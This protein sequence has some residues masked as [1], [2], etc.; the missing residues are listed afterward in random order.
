MMTKKVFLRLA[1]TLVCGLS[2]ARSGWG[3]E[4]RATLGGRVADPQGATVPNAQ[5]EVISDDTGVKQ[6][7]TTNSDGNW[8]VR[9]LIPGHYRFTVTSP[10]FKVAV[11]TGI[12]L[13][14]ADMKSID[15]ELTV[16]SASDHVTVTAEA[17][18]IDTTAA[19]SGTVIDEK[20]MLEVPTNSR[21]AS[22]FAVLSPGVLQQDQN[23]NVYQLWSY[24]A[25]SQFTINGGTNNS[26]S[27]AFEL[28]GMP[29]EM[30]GGKVAFVA[31]PD[32][33]QEFRVLMN[34][35]DAS[36]GRQAGG[37]VQMSLRSGTARYHG[38]LFELNQNNHLNANTF[39]ANLS[40][41]PVPQVHYNE[42][43][44]T[45]GGPVWIPKVYHGKQ[46]TFFFVSNDNFRK[47][48][49]GTGVLG[50][51]TA[52]ERQGDFS[53]SFTTQQ[54]NGQTVRYPIQVYDPLTADSSGARALF[55]GNV[56]P[57]S[58]L[59]SIA[60]NILK[61]VPLPNRPSDPTGNAVNNFASSQPQPGPL[62]LIAV[63]VDQS[64]SDM[65]KTF[66]N[67]RWSSA[68]LGGSTAF[69]KKEFVT[70]EGRTPKG[71]G[72]DHV[73]TV[74]P[75]KVLDLRFTVSRMED[76]NFFAGGDFDPTQLG[77]PA[78]FAA[79]LAKPQF[80]CISGLFNNI[81][82]CHGI[83]DNYSTYYT[84]IANLT[85]VRGNHTL[86]YGAEYWVLQQSTIGLGQLSE[87]DFANNW[88]SNNAITG[89]GTGVGSGLASFLL[90][91]PTGGN[92]P[93]NATSIYSQRY[94][95]FYVHDD[96]R[97]TPKL[98]LNLGL[99]WDGERPPVERFNRMTSNFDPTA[100][101]PISAAA[102]AAYAQILATNPTNVGVQEL[103]QLLPASAFKV[104][105]AQLFAGANGHARTVYN[106]DWKEFQPRVGFAYRLAPDTVVRGGFGRFVQATYDTGGQNGFSVTTP[107]TATTDNYLTPY[108][109]LAN[110][111][112]NGIQSPTGSSLGP[113]TNLGQAVNWLNQ[114]P[115][116]PYSWEY[117]LHVQHQFKSWLFEVGYTHNKTYDFPQSLN[118]NL[119]SFQLH[120]QLL[121]PQFTATGA[122]VATLLWNQ[123]VPNPFYG[124][125]GVTGSMS[126]SKTIAM[127]QLLNPVTILGGITE[128]NNP[129]AKNQYDALLTKVEHRF[130]RGIGIIASF[131][132]SR[133]FQEN[134]FIG[135][136]Q[137]GVV[138]H[139]LGNEDRPLHLSVAP[140][141]EIPVGRGRKVGASMPKV[142][143]A[144]LGGWE[145]SGV[146]T[147]QSGLPVPFSTDSFF[148][149][150]DFA[151]SR[152][153]QNLDKWFD[154]TQFLPFPAKNTNIAIYPA[155]TG[156]QNLPGYNYQPVPS[157]GISNGVYQ[158]FANFVRTFPYSWNDVRA[159]RV[160]NVDGG[161]YKNFQF[162]E[163]LRLQYRFECYN[164]FNHPRFLAPDTNPA[165]STFGQVAKSEQNPP[166]VVQMLLKLYF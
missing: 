65:H 41:A 4:A 103:A 10:G 98:T 71:M 8:S 138:N 139:A 166:R 125:A 37:T 53:Q 143:N 48:G 132:W 69:G 146:F 59:S 3:Q 45:F 80:P 57:A 104:L 93:R 102:Q 135:P 30:Y 90:G 161:I 7:A 136:Q 156:I 105:G 99:R 164:A 43:G 106:A 77:F 28:D 160:N 158:D 153:A 152:S 112:R 75:S 50:V 140:V 120:Q 100:V 97:V 155:W 73:W 60:Q 109:T 81:V 151:I 154:T 101:N 66:A 148:S 165:N 20:H 115:L 13:Q 147:L 91:L 29:N 89:S 9:F 34:A 21:V 42:F 38:S 87:F 121:A 58:R 96:W 11:A 78:S 17:P 108:D 134:S 84:W 70:N 111:F 92:M 47:V 12:E 51:P 25:A 128:S 52:Q 6:G 55:P 2:L 113:L 107:L 62:T 110:P 79:T 76:T 64:W 95:A 61:Y 63:R 5:V 35:Y 94:A 123:L 163:H 119:P 23:N 114:N 85:H 33:I 44:G 15:V 40:G 122:P 54:V 162:R 126:T 127:N 117:S 18:L 150:K 159:S 36:I 141:W 68:V 74:N 116:R 149:G 1:M 49:V 82:G 22:L 142:L 14:T 133:Q 118:E 67:V 144:F 131:T 46:K 88:T 124:L 39:Q 137:L 129:M 19:T 145:L 32:S 86:K 27:T 130:S 26:R 16:G 56:I 24:N 157:D 31:P 72:L 83:T